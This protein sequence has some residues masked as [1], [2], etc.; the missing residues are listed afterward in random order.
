M[1]S[2]NIRVFPNPAISHLNVEYPSF[3]KGN[4]IYNLLDMGAKSVLKINAPSN[5]SH[6]EQIPIQGI[7]SGTYILEV[8]HDAQ[9]FS[10]VVSIE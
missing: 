6:L 10:T 5:E 8:I 9:S 1:S 3:F 2:D 4:V 7:E